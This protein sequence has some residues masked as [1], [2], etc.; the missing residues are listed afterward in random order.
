MAIFS[1]KV[2]WPFFFQRLLYTP[3]FA[4]CA[5]RIPVASFYSPSSRDSCTT[6]L[7]SHAHV[8]TGLPLHCVATF[9]AMLH[10]RAGLH[11]RVRVERV[12][13]NDSRGPL[14]TRPGC[15]RAMRRALYMYSAVQAAGVS[16]VFRS[17][18]TEK[19][20]S[21]ITIIF[22]ISSTPIIRINQRE[23]GSSIALIILQ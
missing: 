15:V 6:A 23:R 18:E 21:I 2:P 5:P 14:V 11:R 7:R 20:D 16:N 1:S 8:T 10:M 12:R 3:L 22:S 19:R 17:V 4:R 13:S 9:V